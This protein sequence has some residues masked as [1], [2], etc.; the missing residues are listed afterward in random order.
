MSLPPPQHPGDLRA[1]S[2]LPQGAAC[3]DIG[4]VMAWGAACGDLGVTADWGTQYG[5]PG[6]T[7]ARARGA[8][9]RDLGVVAVWGAARGPRPDGCPRSGVP[10]AGTAG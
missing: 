8:T 3:R 4:V 6:L 5:D 10:R 1:T 7:T 2:A 9:R